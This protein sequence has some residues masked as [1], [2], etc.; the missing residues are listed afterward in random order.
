[1]ASSTF[2]IT[3]IQYWLHNCWIG[4]DG[5]PCDKAAP[6]ARFVKARKVPKGTPGAKKVKKKSGKWYGRPS[7]GAKPVPLSTNRVAAQQLLAEMVKKAELG[8][9]GINDPYEEHRKRPLAEH[10][11]DFAAYL[12]AKGDGAKHARDT[13]ARVRRVIAGCRFAVIDDITL[14]RVQEFL[15]ALPDAGHSIPPLDPAKESYTRRELAAA[16][17]VKPHSVTILVKRWRLPA[18]GRGKARRYPRATAEALRG[19]LDRGPGATTVNHYGRAV[20]SFTRWLVRD[21]RTGDDA[22]AGLAAV[23]ATAEVRHARRPLITWRVGARPP[24]RPG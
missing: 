8:R 16:L 24:G 3:V 10:L 21:R 9:A 20:R 18:V 23:N 1:M 17:G 12:K 11:A 14:S 7:P 22:L 13:V 15:A 5:L 4:L 6:G 2:K 19:R